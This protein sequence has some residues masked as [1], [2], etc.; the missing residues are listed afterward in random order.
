MNDGS[1]KSKL[2][3]MSRRRP[4]F[5]TRTA[6][7]DVSRLDPN[8]PAQA[9][10]EANSRLLDWRTTLSSRPYEPLNASSRR[11][12]NQRHP[13]STGLFSSISRWWHR[14]DSGSQ[15]SGTDNVAANVSHSAGPRRDSSPDKK[16]KNASAHRA[17]ETAHKLGTFS[18]VF[19]PTTLNVLSILMFLR[20]G[21]VLGQ[22]GLLGMLGRYMLS[23]TTSSV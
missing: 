19:V 15:D 16:E 9:S 12:D 13:S 8:D 10:P 2:G 1:N 11:S 7:E 18:G 17:S 22:A 3:S 14:R 21:F 5:S 20:F 6:E 4:N 23:W